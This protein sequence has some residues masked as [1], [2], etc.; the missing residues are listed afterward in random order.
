MARFH[1]A[2]PVKDLQQTRAFYGELLGAPEGRRAD[3]WVDFDLHGHQLVLHKVSLDEQARLGPASHSE[4][5][6]HRVPVPHFGLVLTLSEWQ[7]LADRLTRAGA[8]FTIAPTVRF[9]GTA[10][11]QRTLF[12][13]DPSG[14]MLEFKGF[15]DV[16]G[17]LFRRDP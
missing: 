6:G 17:E 9:A 11:E 10:G 14:N 3:N 8:E 4:V 12:L 15:A 1:L 7:N 13:A 2:I 16:D 5:D